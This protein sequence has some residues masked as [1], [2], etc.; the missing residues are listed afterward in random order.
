MDEDLASAVDKWLYCHWDTH[1]HDVQFPN[2][3]DLDKHLYT[4][5]FTPAQPQRIPE[6]AKLVE[7]HW[8]SCHETFDIDRVMDHFHTLHQDKSLKP[9]HGSCDD[10]MN[11]SNCYEDIPSNQQISNGMQLNQMANG[12]KYEYEHDPVKYDSTNYGT[13][14]KYDTSKYD[15]AKF[16]P[17]KYEPAKY[18][19][20]PKFEIAKFEAVKYDPSKYDSVKYDTPDHDTSKFDPTK[21]EDPNKCQE[22]KYGDTKYGKQEYESSV[23]NSIEDSLGSSVDG[24]IKSEN[25]DAPFVR[26]NSNSDLGNEN[27]LDP[28]KSLPALPEVKPNLGVYQ[29]MWHV[30][31]GICGAQFLSSSELNAHIVNDHTRIMPHICEWTDCNRA[32][33]PFTQRQKLV[34]HL[35]TH[36]QSCEYKCRTCVKAFNSQSSLQEHALSHEVDKPFTCSICNKCFRARNSYN[37][38]MRVHTGAKPLVCPFPGCGKRFAESSNLAKHRKT[39]L[40]PEFACSTC[41]RMFTRKDHLNRHMKTKGH[42]EYKVNADANTSPNS[43]IAPNVSTNT[44]S[45]SYPPC[46]QESLPKNSVPVVTT[47]PNA[48]G[49][50]GP[51]Y[52]GSA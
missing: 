16:D 7:C 42:G 25:M 51:N 48:T 27:K 47:K 41:H 2:E 23:E 10:N 13:S 31:D 4:H 8:D 17:S 37:I 21:Y 29:C 26:I 5:Y 15:P 40:P 34:R 28:S 18:E 20:A 22:G 33:I 35:Q 30:K 36:A 44:P 24:S 3:E 38:H 32:R 46:I 39:H 14:P 45:K 43:E 52:I 9:H 49:V 6:E 12:A 1:E 11:A 50:V 19:N